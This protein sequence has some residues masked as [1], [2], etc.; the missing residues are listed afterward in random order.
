M[1]HPYPRN[2][3]GKRSADEASHA[4]DTPE[5]TDMAQSQPDR[6]RPACSRSDAF[7]GEPSDRGPI[8]YSGGVTP[9]S[10]WS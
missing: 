2:P 10:L 9:V 5:A 3:T 1:A 6:C 7:G 4:I 8:G